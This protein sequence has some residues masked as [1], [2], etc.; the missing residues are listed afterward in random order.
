MPSHRIQIPPELRGPLLILAIL[1]P[2][3]AFA[4]FRVDAAVRSANDVQRAIRNAQAAR[5]HVLRNALDEETGIRGFILTG[6]DR[7]LEPFNAGTQAMA[8]DFAALSHELERFHLD[9]AQGLVAA[10]R[11]INARWTATIATPLLRA[12]P[13]SR[14]MLAVMREG[15]ALVDD[16]RARDARLQKILDDQ[17]STA[18]QRTQRAI[19]DLTP[20]VIVAVVT[21]IAAGGALGFFQAR[22]ERRAFEARISYQNQK[23]IADA[24]QTAFLNT[25]LPATPELD[26]HATYIPATSEALVGG[27]WYDA[28]ELP[29]KR[30][31]FSIGD[32]AGHGLEAAIVMSRARQAIIAA[33]LHENDPG[34]VLERA[35]AAILLQDARM[36][37]AIC[38][39]IDPATFEVVY[40]TAGHPPPI[41]ARAGA[42]SIVLPH[43]GIPLGILPGETYRTFVAAAGTGA[44]LVLYTDG[45]TEFGRDPIAGER[46]LLEATRLAVLAPDPAKAIERSMFAAVTPSDDVAILTVTFR[47]ALGRA[48]GAAGA[49]RL[50]VP[51]E[52]NVTHT[53]DAGGEEPSAVAP[54]KGARLRDV[55]AERASIAGASRR[56]GDGV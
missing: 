10:E 50:G 37:T 40:A 1:I 9:D 18:E 20:F 52:S 35:N 32:V 13:R 38:G 31:L 12:R 7:Y 41:L 29:D 51:D 27:D 45:V 46:V 54:D 16:F 48:D 22:S 25:H 17:A 30:I 21:L 53:A 2:L 43:G 15:K 42:P 56:L 23:R 36:V 47:A 33:A 14:Q 8:G 5:A 39:Y 34:R 26:L 55:L 6:D 49:L 19:G 4:G 24:L 44:V 3:L 11:A 28:F